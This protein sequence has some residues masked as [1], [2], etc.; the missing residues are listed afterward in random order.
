[1]RYRYEEM[2]LLREAFPSGPLII[3]DTIRQEGISAAEFRPSAQ[4]YAT[5]TLLG[6]GMVSS[7]GAAWQWP[8]CAPTLLFMLLMSTSTLQY[9]QYS[10]V[11]DAVFDCHQLFLVTRFTYHVLFDIANACR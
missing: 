1:M 5:T 11:L 2:R 4:A 10:L 9:S 8:R 3:H 6:E 7:D